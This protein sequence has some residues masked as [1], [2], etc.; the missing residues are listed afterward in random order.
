MI[1][2][3]RASAALVCAGAALL[4]AQESAGSI[5]GRVY[6]P[7]GAAVAGA[8][9]TATQTETGMSRTTRTG[10]DGLYSF[11]NLPIGPYQL[12][13]SREGFKKAVEQGMQ[14]HV[15]EHLGYDITLQ[16]GSVAEEILV[17]A[18]ADQVQTESAEQGGLISGEQVRELQLNGRSFFTLLELV[19]GVTSNL[20]DRTDPNST[21]NVNVNGARSAASNISIDGGNNADVIV[22]SSSMNTFTS[23]ETISEFTV[24]TTPFSAEYGRGGFSQINVV[25][26]G[27]TKTFRGG[28]FHFLRNDA[29]DA[30]D[31]FS[32]QTLP[33]KLNNFGYNIGGPLL[34][35]G[36][37]SGRR[38]TFFF[39]AQEFNRIV[40]RGEAVNTTVPTEAERRGDFS[41]LGTG[42]DG[43]EGT[44]DDPVV[45]PL[46]GLGFP[47]GK[48]PASRIDP[49]SARLMSLY[50]LPNFVGPGRINYT[51][52]AASRQRW[53]EE[54]LRID[55]VFSDYL[56][57][58]GRYTQNSLRLANP[59]GGTSLASVTTRFPGLASTDGTRP[60]KNA[61]INLTQMITPSLMQQF[62]F[63]LA[64]RY[65]DFRANS[66][67]ANRK[68]LGLTLPELFP[69]NEGD[70]IPGISLGSNYAA[71]SPYHVAHKELFNLE[72][73]DHFAR[74]WN[75]HTVK[76]GA[77]YTYGGNLEQPGNVNT[78]GTF[79]F[80][81][82]FSKHQ[83]ANFLLGYPNTYTEVERPVLSD[84]R[85]A[86]LEAYVLDEFRPHRQLTLNVG[87]RYTSYFNPWDIHGVASNFSSA[88]W[89]PARAPQLVRSNGTIVRGTGDPLNGIFVAGK[90]S[91]YGKRIAN[92]LHGLWAPRF[93]FAWAPR[94]RKTSIRGGWGM[95]Y[96]RPL[97]GAF[98]N[99]AFTNPPFGRT[100][101]LNQPSYSDLGGTEAPSTPPA[102]IALGL[103][104]KS[105]TMHQFSFGIQREM[106]R[107]HILNVAYVA[108]RGLRF[109]RPIN[110]NQAE[111]GTLPAGTNVNYI[112]PFKGYGAITERQT[113]GGSVYH[114]LQVSYNRRM[115]K[116][117]TGGV[118]YTWSKSIDDGSS[119]RAAGDV[120]PDKGNTRAERGPSDFDRTHVLTTNFILMAPALVRTPFFRGWQMSGILRFWTGRPADVVMSSDVAQIGAVQNQR[121]DVIA[122]TKGPKTVEEWFNRN[123]FARPAT[124][125]FGN[126]GRNSLRMPGVNKWDLA[127]FKNFQI[128]ER[129]RLQF[130]GEFFNAFNHPNFTTVGL[131]LNTTASG[132]NPLLNSF[133]VVTGTRDARVAQIALKFYF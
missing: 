87:L 83:V 41:S 59:Y 61:V 95:Y 4:A 130:R 28:L 129:K 36:Y 113:S 48:I 34:F 14:L 42:R 94:S 11:P 108:S 20:A 19:P 100:V 23:I 132:V 53:R 51:S 107:G 29:L 82:N 63:T 30:T 16:V 1:R 44:E 43:I 25:T 74:M 13:A 55:H 93:G 24:V 106:L 33:L 79:S 46:T 45:D 67:N 102:L 62:Q 112:R 99:N 131:S 65:T 57:L 91:P 15:S 40:T 12:T 69:E 96:T 6:D 27:G 116:R 105:P 78:G 21:P 10:S 3:V 85:F 88:R 54:M 35:P 8:E 111:P 117:L 80:A 104:L 90:D 31:Y 98:I 22:G 101:T 52:A 60:G 47:G 26:K 72:F 121:P 126:M 127:L 5:T 39:F 97:I 119:D 9:V 7:T 56:K 110:I 103:P 38:K 77:Y 32:H 89:D 124:G 92:D 49:N 2:A 58:Y 120:P 86:G 133:A 115:S 66:D 123:A 18:S 50:P 122:G 84:V 64:T 75:R 128:A 70:V 68:K 37:N 76:F 125:T 81:T 109:Q 73:S 17:T 71:L 114:S 118:A